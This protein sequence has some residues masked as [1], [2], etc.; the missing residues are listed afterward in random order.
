MKWTTQK[1]NKKNRS[2][3]TLQGL[4]NKFGN[5]NLQDLRNII[6]RRKL[7]LF[8]RFNIKLEDIVRFYGNINAN[9]V[10]NLFSN[11]DINFKIYTIQDI[12]NL[13]G[14]QNTIEFC[15]YFKIDIWN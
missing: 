11:I 6:S 8:I 2:I 10:H 13:L 1:E 7:N 3:L 12:I 15:E 4:I 14:D 9:K 5:R